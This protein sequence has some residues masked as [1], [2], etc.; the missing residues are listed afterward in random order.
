MPL[1]RPLLFAMLLAFGACAQAGK[2]GFQG[3]GDS[4]ITLVDADT[5]HP[6]PDAFVSHIDTPPNM[7][8]KTLDENSNDTIDLQH[9]LACSSNLNNVPQYTL[10]NSYYRVF[11]PSQFGIT[12]DFHV[13]QVTFQVLEATPGAGVTVTLKVGTYTGS[14]V[15]ATLDTAAMTTIATN[16]AVQV[17]HIASGGTGGTVNQAITATIPAG[18]KLFTEVDAPELPNGQFF[19][20]GQ[21]T[22][23]DTLPSYM[24][25]T[26]CNVNAPQTVKSLN[27]NTQLAELMTVT[28]TY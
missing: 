28:G 11:D 25:A 22:A 12:T 14:L 15:G 19:Y 17:P 26:D 5:S 3:V 10:A 1:M 13:T 27:G 2:G 4:G 20:F 21:N 7:M 9:S 6:P 16:A 23:T 18:T 24:L 8:T